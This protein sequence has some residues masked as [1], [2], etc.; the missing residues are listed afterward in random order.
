MGKDYREII[1]FTQPLRGPRDLVGM[2]VYGNEYLSDP[3]LPGKNLCIRV[4]IQMY[5]IYLNF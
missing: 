1:K 3:H 5:N 4:R 2:G